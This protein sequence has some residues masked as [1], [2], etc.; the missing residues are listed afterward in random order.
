MERAIITEYSKVPL[1]MSAKDIQALGFSRSMT[2]NFLNRADFPVIIIGGR[3][4]V[5][6]DRFLDG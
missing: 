5:Q 1:V 3:K 6:R 4:M 2:Y